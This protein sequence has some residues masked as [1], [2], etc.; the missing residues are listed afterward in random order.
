MGSK[1]K[2]R[3]PTACTI[4]N[5]VEFRG[6]RALQWCDIEIMASTLILLKFPMLLSLLCQSVANWKVC[7]YILGVVLL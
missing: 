2:H 7:C 3:T 4:Q 6:V 1:V 5:I